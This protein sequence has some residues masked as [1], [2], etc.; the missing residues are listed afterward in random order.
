MRI[1]FG[2]IGRTLLV[3]GISLLILATLAY[4]IRPTATVSNTL[5]SEEPVNNTSVGLVIV[6]SGN[7]EGTVRVEFY[8]KYHVTEYLVKKEAPQAFG[9]LMTKI[10]Q[11]NIASMEI[12]S[13]FRTGSTV[14]TLQASYD[15]KELL[16]EYAEAR[17][18]FEVDGGYRSFPIR[19]NEVLILFIQPVGL[20]P[21]NVHVL[22]YATGLASVEIQNG[23]IIGILLII[24]SIVYVLMKR[25]K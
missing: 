8:G 4:F 3:L 1:V 14:V 2:A 7:S 25:K 18:S 17:E 13:D 22:F 15:I 6:A 20:E 21:L 10:Y 5:Y 23:I 16:N 11:Y 9:S 12:S 24:A 19:L